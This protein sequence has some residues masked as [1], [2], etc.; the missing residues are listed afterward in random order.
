MRTSELTRLLTAPAN[1][2]Q[3]LAEATKK[4]RQGNPGEEAELGAARQQAVRYD[5]ELYGFDP[6]K[7]RFSSNRTSL[8][9]G[10]E[11]VVPSMLPEAKK[12]NAD[13]AA[14]NKGHEF[15]S[16]LN[17]SLSERCILLNQ[18]KIPLIPGAN[19]GNLVQIV[20]GAGHVA[21]LRAS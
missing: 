3:E 4:A 15:D 18:E 10:P 1:T 7:L 8:I 2:E 17:R 9:V 6:G 14:L 5:L 19:E 21:L 13:R 11:G 16:Y 20:Q 12:R